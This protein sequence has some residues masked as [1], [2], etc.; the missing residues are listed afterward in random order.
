M[1]PCFA[2]ALGAELAALFYPLLAVIYGGVTFPILAPCR[3]KMRCR[4]PGAVSPPLPWHHKSG[5]GWE[6]GRSWHNHSGA[7]RQCQPESWL[8]WD[9]MG[10]LCVQR[11]SLPPPAPPHPRYLVGNQCL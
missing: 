3:A 8:P 6:M 5:A 10:T 1:R 9:R 7:R 4:S 2:A 11:G